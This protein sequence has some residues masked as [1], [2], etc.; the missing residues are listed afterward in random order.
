[1]RDLLIAGLHRD[2]KRPLTY[3]CFILSLLCGVI[4]AFSSVHAD[5]Y[6]TT[7]FTFKPDDY[8]WAISILLN[9]MLLV[10]N[11]GMEFSAGAIRN[12]ITAGYTKHQIYFSETLISIL[13]S[14]VM[15]CLTGIPFALYC[16]SYLQNMTYSICAWVTILVS[17]IFIGLIT[18]FICFVS[19][20]RTVA[21]IISLML[22]FGMYW[23]SYSLENKLRMPEYYTTYHHENGDTT[24]SLYGGDDAEEAM[25]DITEITHEPNPDYIGGSKRIVLST[26]NDCNSFTALK[27][28]SLYCYYTNDFFDGDRAGYEKENYPKIKRELVSICI[29][30]ILVS[31]SGALIFKRKNL[32]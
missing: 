28:F 10:L 18:I 13:F 8:F 3:I 30:S 14:I 11:I 19:A 31:L 21:A 27:V 17:Y 5:Y 16:Y 2:L 20:N 6:D 22:V 1:M 9:V 29:V 25:E 24:T 12:K 7:Q 32:K 15:F 23:V 26:L 4:Y